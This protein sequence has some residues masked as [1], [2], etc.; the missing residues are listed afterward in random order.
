MIS[1]FKL[2]QHLFCV[3]K[4][5][6]MCPFDLF[7]HQMLELSWPQIAFT[8]AKFVISENVNLR[9]SKNLESL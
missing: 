5:L 8:I 6:I 3:V 9:I 4:T 1:P 2:E 7:T